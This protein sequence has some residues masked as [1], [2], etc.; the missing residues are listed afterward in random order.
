MNGCPPRSAQ[1]QAVAAPRDERP[2]VWLLA[3][4]L[5]AMACWNS[6]EVLSFDFVGRDDDINLYF[7]PHLGPPSA[8]S[9]TWMFTDIAYMR[10]YVPLGWLGFASVYEFSGLSPVGYHAANLGLHGAN[11]LLVYAL[12]LV[13]V[14]RFGES[15]EPR[16]QPIA[17]AMGAALW[18]WHP[19]RAE[20]IGWSSGLFYGAAGFWAFLSLLAYLRVS[21][22]GL[23]GRQRARWLV[24][25][26]LFYTLSIFTYPVGI[27]LALVFIVIDL[28]E[29]QSGKKVGSPGWRR[30]A[31]EKLVFLLP[32]AAMMALTVI[33]RFEVSAFWPRPPTWDE[34]TLLQRVVQA[35]AV[36]SYYVWKTGWPVGL[37]L[38]PTWLFSVDPFRPIFAASTV[39]VVGVTALLAVRRRWRNGL[40]LWVAYLALLAPLVGFTDHPHFS[41]DRY[42][43]LAGVAISVVVV[44]G[45]LACRHLLRA[46]FV[47]T[48]CLALLGLGWLQRA[49]LQVW[50]DTDT[51]MARTLAQSDDVEFS[52]DNYHKWAMFHAHRGRLVR[53]REILAAADRAAPEHPRVR[54]L[55]QELVAYAQPEENSSGSRP[56]PSASQLHTKLALDFSR[57][58][59]VAEAHEHFRLARRLA[60]TSGTLAF[61]WAVLCAMTGEPSRSLALYFSALGGAATDRPSVPARVRLLMLIA[62]SFHAT[63]QAPPALRAARAAVRLAQVSADPDLVGRARAQLERVGP[64]RM[65]AD[66]VP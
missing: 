21:T 6:R 51:L 63:N 31:I 43:Y 24:A 14:R 66:A 29:W 54:A 8:Q 19:F 47:A 38:A 56:R 58:G 7:N 17:A 60:P 27:A 5:V 13:L 55:R 23:T 16:W 3:V 34:F 36:W 9:L 20:T 32:G 62:D 18:S 46:V 59:R 50:Q 44:F 49:Q 2:I 52:T 4:L 15:P 22:I 64:G 42:S 37:T 61:N 26:A 30:L 11:T 39:F 33:G 10:R 48:A 45:V 40:L 57:A 12:L 28:A 53:A 41:S 1:A 35:C 25:A 65:R